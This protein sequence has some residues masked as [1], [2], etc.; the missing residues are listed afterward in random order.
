MR[1]FVNAIDTLAGQANR[2]D[3]TPFSGDTCMRDDELAPMLE[4]VDKIIKRICGCS[5]GGAVA[6]EAV[7]WNGIRGFSGQRGDNAAEE[8]ERESR[9][10]FHCRLR[11][12]DLGTQIVYD[13]QVIC[14][15]HKNPND[16]LESNILKKC[17]NIGDGNQFVDGFVI[18]LTGPETA[19]DGN[20]ENL[21]MIST[22]YYYGCCI[23]E[24]GCRVLRPDNPKATYFEKKPLYKVV[25]I[26]LAA[27]LQI[28][29]NSTMASNKLWRMEK[30]T[31]KRTNAGSDCAMAMSYQSNYSFPLI[32][33]RVF[34]CEEAETRAV[35]DGRTA[36]FN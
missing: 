26:V 10:V 34:V 7:M 5:T 11:L 4:T 3:E 24:N 22:P 19:G 23:I 13:P 9:S 28:Y 25:G 20:Q 21:P 30:V 27:N 16:S 17:T 15:S 18:H 6:F 8:D 36:S 12:G 35:F 33:G 1:L 2:S 32:Q 31:G 14:T 29:T